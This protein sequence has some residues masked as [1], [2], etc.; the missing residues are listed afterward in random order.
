MEK[1]AGKPQGD[2]PCVWFL[3]GATGVGK[4]EL[5]LL[6]AERIGGAILS[7][8]SM[9]VYRGLDIGTA[10]PT[11]EER[12]RV[13][14]GGLDLVDLGEEC[15]VAR[16][17]SHAREFLGAQAQA[18]RTVLAVGGTG[19][20]FRALTRGL[21][22]APPPD[23]RLRRFLEGLPREELVRRLWEADP[24]AAARVDLSNPRRILRALEVKILTGQSLLRWQATTTRPLVESY[25]AVWLDRER[26]ELRERIRARVQKLL[27]GGWIEEV[28]ALVDRKG[29]ELVCQC[30]AIGYR[31]IALWLRA[32]GELGSLQ[33][34]IAGRTWAFARRQLTWFRRE[35]NVRYRMIHRGEEPTEL[36]ESLLAHFQATG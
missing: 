8:D 24:E 15:S 20:Y 10:K 19:L 12:S 9:Q 25:R 28:R 32:G 3:V 11:P 35:I 6:L 4:S 31:E 13:P 33:E 7:L 21:C 26:K 30:P 5:A 27:A 16:F 14:H 29:F 1:D 17:L 36:A 2:M 22:A 34:Q 18:G 23:P